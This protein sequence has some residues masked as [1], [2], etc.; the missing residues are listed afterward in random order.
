MLIEKVK[1]QYY[2]TGLDVEAAIQ[3][4]RGRYRKT[5][6]L[7]AGITQ[8]NIST[9]NNNDN[10]SNGYLFLVISPKEHI[11][12]YNYKKPK[13]H[14]TTTQPIKAWEYTNSNGFNELTTKM[15]NVSFSSIYESRETPK[16]EPVGEE[17]SK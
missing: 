3:E 7:A 5:R 14:T 11:S 8:I 15:E 4:K 13:N 1:H 9:Q 10:D 6:G 2:K 16:S 12:C 17:S